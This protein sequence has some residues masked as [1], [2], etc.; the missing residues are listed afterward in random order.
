MRI[1]NLVKQED[2]YWY[3]VTGISNT[4]THEICAKNIKEGVCYKRMKY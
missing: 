3:I 4:S 2:I 1:L